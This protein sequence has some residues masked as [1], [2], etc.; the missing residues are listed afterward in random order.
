MRHQNPE[1]GTTR[2]SGSV[3]VTSVEYDGSF[4]RNVRRTGKSGH[5]GLLPGAIRF[6]HSQIGVAM[7]TYT[8]VPSEVMRAAMLGRGDVL[9][10]CSDGQKQQGN[11]DSSGR[12][13][14]LS[15]DAVITPAENEDR[16]PEKGL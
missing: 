12:A 13:P 16:G 7:N 6:G 5:R 1:P 10:T 4:R 11:E 15:S 8:H 9:D 2:R 3:G 14:G